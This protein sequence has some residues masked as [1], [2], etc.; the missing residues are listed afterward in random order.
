MRDEI[1]ST[2]E[3]IINHSLALD[4]PTE[5]PRAAGDAT[6]PLDPLG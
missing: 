4:G 1:K 2:I 6:G 5:P 3:W